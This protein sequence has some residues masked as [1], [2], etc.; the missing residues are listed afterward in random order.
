MYQQ[1]PAEHVDPVDPVNPVDPVDPVNPVHPVD[2]VEDEGMEVEKEEDL[3]S[4][5]SDDEEV[6]RKKRNKRQRKEARQSYQE[7]RDV[8]SLELS[9]VVWAT[10]EEFQTWTAENYQSGIPRLTVM[11]NVWSKDSKGRSVELKCTKLKKLNRF[12]KF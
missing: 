3:A 6:L 4:N 12:S 7:E 1:N 10:D 5:A 2:P 11:R 8:D 9:T